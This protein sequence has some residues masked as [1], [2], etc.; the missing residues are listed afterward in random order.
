VQKP[1]RILQ[2][3]QQSDRHKTY[4]RG[5]IEIF[6]LSLRNSSPRR[7]QNISYPRQ[8]AMY[9]CRDIM[10]LSLPKIGEE[11]GGRDHTTVIHAIQK[12]EGDIQLNQETKRTIEE[13]KRNVTGK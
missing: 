3:Q 4:Y 12:I 11:F 7:E 9:L 2:P 10:G 6:D 1:Q 8:I 13:L 5:R